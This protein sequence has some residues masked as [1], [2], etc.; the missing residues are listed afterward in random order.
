MYPFHREEK[1]EAGRRWWLQGVLVADNTWEA[2]VGWVPIPPQSAQGGCGALWLRGGA[3]W[4][5]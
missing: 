3:G 5:G 1:T 2:T 4:R